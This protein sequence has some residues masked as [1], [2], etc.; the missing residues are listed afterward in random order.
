MSTSVAA[1]GSADAIQ[2]S[3]ALLLVQTLRDT[4]FDPVVVASADDRILQA[5][6]NSKSPSPVT[7]HA[8]F[9]G[10]RT[11]F[12]GSLLQAVHQLTG[13]RHAG[14]QNIAGQRF[15]DVEG[16]A[17]RPAERAVVQVMM[18]RTV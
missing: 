4:H 9:T 7:V 5:D 12:S 2:L 11:R 10:H 17:V 1:C 16:L 8:F 13:D 3:T 18:V 6:R 15:G 14:R